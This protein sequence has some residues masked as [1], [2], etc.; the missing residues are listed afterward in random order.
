[1][2]Q[3]TVLNKLW[4]KRSSIVN[5]RGSP[6]APAFCPQSPTNAPQV[7]RSAERLQEAGAQALSVFSRVSPAFIYY[8]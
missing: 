7:L 1:M 6:D 4:A 2:S 5:K 3:G 8:Y